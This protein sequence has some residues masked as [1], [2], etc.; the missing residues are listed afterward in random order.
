MSEDRSA[1][2]NEVDAA[3]GGAMA[4][5]TRHALEALAAADWLRAVVLAS[6]AVALA[7]G[8][9]AVLIAISGKNPLVAYG[10]TGY[11]I[12]QA[13]VEHCIGRDRQTPRYI[14][15]YYAGLGETNGFGSVPDA[16]ALPFWF[17]VPRRL[18]LR[19]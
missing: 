8:V 10:A 17:G 7:L 2:V 12:P 19:L 16:A 13:K 5:A 18:W 9:T 11:W 1:R 6:V 15:A 3:D 14:A 4:T